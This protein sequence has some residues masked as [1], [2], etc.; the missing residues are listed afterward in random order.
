ML[1]ASLQKNVL[2]DFYIYLFGT[3]FVETIPIA[4]VQQTVVTLCHVGI[5]SNMHWAQ[6]KPNE[7]TFYYLLH[8]HKPVL[9]TQYLLN[10]L[11]SQ[12]HSW[13]CFYY[14]KNLHNTINARK[15]WQHIQVIKSA[16]TNSIQQVLK[17]ISIPSIALICIVSALLWKSML[18]YFLNGGNLHGS[19]CQLLCFQT[20]FDFPM[21]Y[22]SLYCLINIDV[23][24]ISAVFWTS[25]SCF[26]R[27]WQ[28]WSISVSSLMNRGN[29]SA[30][31]NDKL[32]LEV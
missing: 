15:N 28:M 11:T 6:T 19:L 18:M 30:R 14:T 1:K 21:H 17:Q 13:N 3:K 9:Y 29:K 8:Q 7:K 22:S 25:L 24:S 2:T 12:T 32:D 10:V 5:N 20:Y 31:W 4:A 27:L 16:I 23:G 26:Q